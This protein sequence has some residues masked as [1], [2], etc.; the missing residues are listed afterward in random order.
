MAE[1]VGKV[2]LTNGLLPDGLLPRSSAPQW[3]V[4]GHGASSL[5]CQDKS[6]FWI[7][8]KVILNLM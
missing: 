5:V 3:F 6:R 2:M 8:F 7:R 1:S 4:V